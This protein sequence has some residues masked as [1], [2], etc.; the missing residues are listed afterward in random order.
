MITCRFRRHGL[1]AAALLALAGCGDV[2]LPSFASLAQGAVPPASAKALS[3]VKLANG[4]LTVNGTDD[5]C[6]EPR[7]L[8]NSSRA[9]F[10]MLAGCYELTDGRNGAQTP[11]GFV[12]IS[13]GPVQLD[14][15]TSDALLSDVLRGDETISRSERRGLALA[16][17]KAEAG[18]DA[19]P[20]WR[21]V[22]V[23]GRRPALI[24]V[25]A[26]ENGSLAGAA[27]GRLAQNI[28]DGLATQRVV[29]EVTAA[30]DAQ[31]APSA[32]PGLDVGALFGRL[33]NRNGSE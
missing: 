15:T 9:S 2:P 10:A 30:S 22:S 27:G 25:H 13:V 4:A 29:E 20:V 21:G 18:A 32:Q 23:I 11:P 5:W 1:T 12:T 7:S 6:I 16:R 26:P 28:A 17:V 8:R 33:L 24:T 31:T 19:S 14:P 3:Q